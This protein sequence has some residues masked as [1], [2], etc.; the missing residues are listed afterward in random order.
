VHFVLI[1]L[2]IGVQGLGGLPQ[3]KL[4]LGEGPPPDS[5]VSGL[6]H[7]IQLK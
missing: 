5:S 6:T 1:E 4:H 2:V 3:H 7:N